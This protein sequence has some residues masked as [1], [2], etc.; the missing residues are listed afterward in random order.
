MK[1]SLGF[2]EIL[3]KI[4]RFSKQFAV[5][6]VL[7]ALVVSI[8]PPTNMASAATA[9]KKYSSSVIHVKL[10]SG[11]NL[12]FANNGI[13]GTGASSF[14]QILGKRPQ[15]VKRMFGGDKA[16]LDKTYSSFR[17]QG[18]NV[19]QLSQYLEIDLGASADTKAISKRLKP[20]PGVEE[21]YPKPLPAPSP[22]S[23]N[24]VAKQTYR[25]AAP[26]GVNADFAAT[27]PGAK[28]D[29]VK[30]ADLEYSWNTAHEDLAKA[31]VAGTK[32]AVMTPADPFN[33]A[34]HGT[35]VLGILSG[36]S[37]TVGVTGV[38]PNSPLALVN[39]Y[40]AEA[41]W[42]IATAVYAAANKLSPGD[43]ILIEQ[44]MWG[45]TGSDNDFVPVEWLPEIYD[46]IV[47]A[48]ARKITVVEPAGNGNQNLDN[49]A[50]YGS[51][52]PSGKPDSGA[53]IVGA[54]S[55]CSGTTTPK[56]SRMYFSS[57]G[58]RVNLQGWGECVTT[59]GYGDAYNGG[60]NSSYTNVF[61]GTSSASPM[62]A[63][64]VASYVSSYKKL[65][66]TVPTPVSIRAA[67]Q[68]TGTPQSF[69]S[70]S[71]TGNI[72]QLPNLGKA[73]ILTDLKAPSKPTGVAVKLN[74]SNKPYLTWKASTDNVGVAGYRV[75]RNGVYVKY[76]TTTS[77]TDTTAAKAKKYT[78]AVKS[79]DRAGRLS[80]LS[81]SVSITTK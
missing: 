19:A 49:T 17:S 47:Y 38:A 63:A 7:S 76:V 67:L 2:A 39:T 54:G 15:S 55:A 80:A 3:S 12:T 18:Y 62:V 25:K 72:G 32:I 73:L 5:L 58:K 34:N 52:F 4:G 60:V 11:S 50:Y 70:G 64:S 77:F 28:G 20:L 44:Q 51:T 31:R 42:D 59:T 45:A 36:Q 14:N 8:L 41:G 33:D 26:T 29:S 79:V 9:L 6:I 57:Y 71:L 22:A 78:Y 1:S 68:K 81:S 35:A 48:T 46:A 23:P 37:N 56:N 66:G 30:I 69:A 53:I 10:R 21:A 61:S 75:Y 13:T 24:L 65:N 27:W 40:S 43:V 74:T 16:A